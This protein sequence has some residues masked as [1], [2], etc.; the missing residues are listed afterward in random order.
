MI[1]KP[2]YSTSKQM[3]W[4]SVTAAWA[5]IVA[6]TVGAVLGEPNAVAFGTVAVPSMCALIGGMLGIHRHYG[7][8]DMEIM[9]EQLSPPGGQP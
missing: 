1:T 2:A 4:C 7:S 9:A 3:L 6:L 5:V 8:R